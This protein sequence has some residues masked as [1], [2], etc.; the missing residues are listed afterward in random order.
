MSIEIGK[1]QVCLYCDGKGYKLGGTVMPNGRIVD[2]HKVHC[3]HCNGQGKWTW[4][5]KPPWERQ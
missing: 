5:N 4:W 1:E 2:E 3:C